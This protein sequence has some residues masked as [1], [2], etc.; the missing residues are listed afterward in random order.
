MIIK[1]TMVYGFTQW[2]HKLE[3]KITYYIKLTVIQKPCM[4]LNKV[5]NNNGKIQIVLT[6]ENEKIKGNLFV[7]EKKVF[8]QL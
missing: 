6:L 5:Y 2:E 7:F 1:T 4:L 3:Y 8:F